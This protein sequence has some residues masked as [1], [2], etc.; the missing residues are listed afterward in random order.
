MPGLQRKGRMVDCIERG[1]AP[2]CIQIVNRRENAIPA[3]IW[4][5]RTITRMLMRWGAQNWPKPVDFRVEIVCNFEVN[6]SKRDA[7][8]RLTRGVG[9]ALYIIKRKT[10]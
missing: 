6:G 1:D 3:D 10:C 2:N 7:A 5:N 9:W 4:K 8:M